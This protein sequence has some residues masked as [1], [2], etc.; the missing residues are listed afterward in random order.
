M[1]LFLPKTR[2]A[3]AGFSLIEVLVVLVIIG[4]IMGLV[5]GGVFQKSD[6]SRIDA[7]KI[8][9]QSFKNAL[10]LF[11]LNVGRFPTTDEGLKVL[12]QKPSD[13]ESGSKWSGPYLKSK[14]VPKDPWNKDY[15]YQLN[16]GGDDNTPYY[17]YTEG[18]PGKPETRVGDL[19]PQ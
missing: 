8:Q 14:E 17:L 11:E 13:E 9:I 1:N 10:E 6:K 18:A 5:A 4:L 2:Q 16:E 7:A 19:P 3:Q 15:V 12:I